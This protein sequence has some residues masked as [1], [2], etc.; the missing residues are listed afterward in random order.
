MPVEKGTRGRWAAKANLADSDADSE[1][2][3]TC[4]VCG[5]SFDMRDLA[6][7]AYHEAEMHQPL[8]GH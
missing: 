2:I 4:V 1:H 5:Q 8:P 6:Q 7:L 3:L